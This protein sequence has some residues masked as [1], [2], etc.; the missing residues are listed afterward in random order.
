ML[1]HLVFFKFHPHVEEPEIADLEESLR[2][3][4]QTI[5]EIAGFEVGRDV[6]HS[7]RSYDLAL[8]STFAD[9]DALQVYQVHPDHQRV[10]AKVRKLCSSVAAVD[11]EI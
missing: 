1:R 7:E 5:A 6:L 9:L 10:V 3:L 4:P 2:A 8:V 11:F